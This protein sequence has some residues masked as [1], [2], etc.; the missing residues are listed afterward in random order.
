[1]I[2]AAS[3]SAERHKLQTGRYEE[4]VCAMSSF[5]PT[6]ANSASSGNYA[7]FDDDGA[8]FFK[9]KTSDNVLVCMHA[10]RVCVCVFL[11]LSVVLVYVL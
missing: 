5:A 8:E 7:A 2:K 10:W 6:S 1:M 9:G 11:T 3:M 4:S